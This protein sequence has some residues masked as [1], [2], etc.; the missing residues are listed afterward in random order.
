MAVRQLAVQKH[1]LPT[2]KSGK[3]DTWCA[4]F[5]KDVKTEQKSLQFVKKLLAVG[6]STL[7]YLRNLFPETAYRDQNCEG[8]DLKI[9]ITDTDPDVAPLIDWISGAFDAVD[10]KYLRQLT[11]A[12]S[13]NKNPDDPVLEEYSFFFTYGDDGS[14]SLNAISSSNIKTTC[15]GRSGKKFSK[16]EVRMC[17]K[18]LLRSIII[19][20]QTMP[21][22]PKKVYMTMRILYYDEV[23]PADYEPQGFRSTTI[24]SYSFPFEPAVFTMGKVST[25]HHSLTVKLRVADE[26]FPGDPS[27]SQDTGSS[28]EAADGPAAI[29]AVVAAVPD[30]N[31][32]TTVTTTITASP[33]AVAAASSLPAASPSSAAIPLSSASPFPA[34]VLSTDAAVQLESPGDPNATSTPLLSSCLSLPSLVDNPRLDAEILATAS[35]GCTSIAPPDV[36]LNANREV[37]TNDETIGISIAGRENMNLNSSVILMDIGPSVETNNGPRAMEDDDSDCIVVSGGYDRNIRKQSQDFE[38]NADGNFRR[39]TG[40][41]RC[42]SNF[43][44]SP[45]SLVPCLSKEKPL[46]VPKGSQEQQVPCVVTDSNAGSSATKQ[47]APLDDGGCS[48]TLSEFAVKLEHPQAATIQDVKTIDLVENDFRTGSPM[49][50]GEV[51]LNKVQQQLPNKR[52]LGEGDETPL[53]FS[54]TSEEIGEPLDSKEGVKCSE[55]PILNENLSASVTPYHTPSLKAPGSACS[56]VSQCSIRSV[57]VA[58]A[59]SQP[60]PGYPVRCA[61]LANVDHGL[62]ILCDVCGNWQHGACF[63]IIRAEDAPERHVCQLCSD[64]PDLCTDPRLCYLSSV[65]LEETCLFRRCVAMLRTTDVNANT[66]LS[67]VALAHSLQCDISKATFVVEQ[68]INA[69]VLSTVRNSARRSSAKKLIV[70][71]ETLENEAVPK[72]FGKRSSQRLE[73]EE[74]LPVE[75]SA[76]AGTS[77]EWAPRPKKIKAS[78]ST[79]VMEKTP[80]AKR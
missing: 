24:S 11:L 32:L 17:T 77:Q 9:L 62:M 46:N 25:G 65:K 33:A 22:L 78:M 54:L 29:F 79:T 27:Q 31:H 8:L 61:C 13:C 55:S 60:S 52:E 1:S 12:I 47:N 68:L 3:Q 63:G 44:T 39:S 58:L 23:T 7:T 36:S 4:L 80:Q 34:A 38:T 69:G 30:S 76:T 72:F 74:P 16:H 28:Q 6:I 73:S 41:R 57:S 19:L 10:K 56:A 66:E 40:L 64:P 21:L 49:T 14:A 51:E 18:K 2:P 71:T 75:E 53:L 59:P 37:S 20:T 45:L 15:D 70:N 26:Q 48:S 67:T 42:K 50:S 35:V 43:W 5:P